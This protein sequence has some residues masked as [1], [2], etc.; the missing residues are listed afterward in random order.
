M[1]KNFIYIL[2]NNYKYKILIIIILLLILIFI[3]KDTN[4]KQNSNY[5]KDELLNLYNITTPI[6]YLHSGGNLGNVLLILNNLI[7]ICENIKCKYI[8]TPPGLDELIKN[9]IFYKEY[10]ITILPCYYKNKDNISLTLNPYQALIFRYSNKIHNIRMN[11]LKNEILSNLPK[12]NANPNDLYINIRSGDVFIRTIHDKYAQPPLC[13]Y[14]KII[15]ENNYSNIYLISNGHENPVVDVLLK[16]YKKIKY[17]HGSPLEDASV[18]VNAYNLILPISSFPYSLLRLNNNLKRVYIYDIL[19]E[20]EKINWYG[21]DYYFQ[22]DNFTIYKMKP[23]LTYESI[24]KGKWKN[25]TEQLNLM[26]KEKCINSSFNIIS[27]PK[28]T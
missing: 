9:I 8:V 2:K 11:I 27:K 26:I 19:V 14:K 6:E 16:L 12:Y 3:I 1:K 25:A 20:E 21:T 5:L 17:I 28:N 4:I 15:N 10:N 24:M 18:I 7:N 23:S 13:F 22:F